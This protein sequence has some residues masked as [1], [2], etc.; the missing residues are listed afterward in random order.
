MIKREELTDPASCMS[1]AH[2]DEMTF[3]LL[4]RDIAAAATIR[5]WIG[6]R[7][8]LGKNIPA[9]PQIQEALNVAEQI[10]R[11]NG[12]TF[13]AG[14]PMC[15][16]RP[17]KK[18]SCVHGDS[19]PNCPDR[20]CPNNHAPYW[21]ELGS[22]G[23]LRIPLSSRETHSR[24][25]ARMD[26]AIASKIP[27]PADAL[28]RFEPIAELMAVS[29]P[30]AQL[31]DDALEV[32]KSFQHDTILGLADCLV[33]FAHDMETRNVKVSP[34]ELKRNAQYLRDYADT[35]VPAGPEEPR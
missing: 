21:H 3:V 22:P 17:E 25:T 29:I 9:D 19:E 23:C 18:C 1:R 6:V 13:H 34:E 27:K 4:G 10:E 33:S 28:Q 5:Y 26:E 30:F 7:I 20:G 12:I 32:L 14:T 35:L 16:C 15:N 11:G 31:S 24:N 8:S 2:Y